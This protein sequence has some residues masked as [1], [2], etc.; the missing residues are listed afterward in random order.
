MNV[1]AVV[2]VQDS[3][4]VAGEGGRVRLLGVMVQVRPA[5][6]VSVKMTVPAKPFRA[7]TVTVEV[8]DDPTM[9]GPG[10]VFAMVKSVKVKVV[11]A[12]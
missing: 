7:V 3:V 9:T 4:A 12:E 5:G 11:V 10:D 2:E 8:A 6:T 1:P